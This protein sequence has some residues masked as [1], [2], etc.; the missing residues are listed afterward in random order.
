MRSL[1]H[2]VDELLLERGQ[3][4]HFVD[5][6]DIVV[7]PA[8]GC[9]SLV[10][11]EDPKIRCEPELESRVGTS[12]AHTELTVPIRDAARRSAASLR[13]A[14]RSA[15]RARPSNSAAAFRVNVVAIKPSGR[16]EPLEMASTRTSVSR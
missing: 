9:G 7:G 3:L 12:R 13:P 4:I 2:E 11:V 15:R 16:A 1:P 5:R 8:Q 6:E 10:G 14:L